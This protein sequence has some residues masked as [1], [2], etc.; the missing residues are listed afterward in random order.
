MPGIFHESGGQWRLVRAE[1]SPSLLRLAPV[2]MEP[3]AAASPRPGA[4]TC[5]L[6]QIEAGRK[7][8]VLVSGA[9]ALRHNGAP[10]TAGLRILD[11]RDAIGLDGHAPL[12]FSTEELAH[13]ETFAFDTSVSCPR[14]RS[15]VR[16][17]DAVVRCPLCGVAH[18]E[19]PERNC[20]TYAE[21]CALCAQA[22]ALDAGLRWTPEDL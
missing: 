3:A 2:S 20:W 7:W 21:T 1:E 8:A 12:F 19:T 10:V 4:N 17:G 18:H 14:C 11:H 15:E 13:V 6:V 22:T 16:H 9:V 5:L